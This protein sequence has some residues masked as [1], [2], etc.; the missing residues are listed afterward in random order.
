MMP[1]QKRAVARHRNRQ[2]SKGISRL[3]ISVPKEDKD[4]LR[5]AAAKLK[6]GGVAAGRVRR[7]LRDAVAD[8]EPISFKELLESAPLDGIEFERSADTGREI[9]L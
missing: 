4:L 9:E 7:A 6:S 1:S 2:Q 5:A 8:R 3:E